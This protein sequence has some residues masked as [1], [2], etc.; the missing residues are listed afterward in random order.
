MR[1]GR[2]FDLTY[3]S[4]IHAGEQW[5]QVQAALT[6][7][8]PAIRE[9]LRHRGPLAIGLRL[10]AVAADTLEEPATF[11][12]FRAFLREGEYYVPTINGFPYG[13]FHGTRV[14]ERVYEPDWRDPRRVDYSN[15]LAR[16]LAT[17]T[18]DARRDR[19]S[20]STVPGAFR[21]HATTDADRDAIALGMLTH[22]AYLAQLYDRT[23]V[24]VTLAIEPEPAC[25]METVA[26]AVWFFREE[27]FDRQNLRRV[28]AQTGVELT[29]GQVRRHL[30]L[31]LDACHMAVEFEDPAGA[32]DAAAGEGLTVAKVQLSSA[33][34]VE[35]SAELTPQTL[36]APFAEDTYL[37]QV[38]IAAG[39]RVS[40]YT[41]LPDALDAPSAATRGEW[42]VHFHVPIFLEQMSGFDT[43]QAYLAQ[44]LRLLQQREIATCL[45]VETYT[46][47]VLPEMYRTTDVCTAIAREL[48]W[49]RDRLAP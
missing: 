38:V 6:A 46:W 35:A 12:R 30:G 27:L 29:A 36:L 37:H 2:S 25:V 26:E 9:T 5:D 31:C 40:R 15:R 1:I 48:T 17:V 19:A 45:E 13:A 21:E 16:I 47:D 20:I 22:A 41:D 23:G 4:N 10:A 7:S 39:E 42:R 8:L 18:A 44:M 24:I 43:T 14:K 49:V 33:L 11:E 28:A 3:C 32:L 34:R